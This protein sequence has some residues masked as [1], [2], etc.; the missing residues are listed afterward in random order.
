MPRRRRNGPRKAASRDW[1]A[2][3]Q[4]ER[5]ICCLA[6]ATSARVLLCRAVA[7][8]YAVPATASTPKSIIRPRQRLANQGPTFLSGVKRA[9]LADADKASAK[10]AGMAA[11]AN[12]PAAIP[13]ARPQ[14]A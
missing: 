4:S 11:I 3:S 6:A 12:V 9:S 14:K 10:L 2:A 1:T 13:Y 7:Q 5:A 8:M